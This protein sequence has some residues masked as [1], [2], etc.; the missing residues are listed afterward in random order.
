MKKEEIYFLRKIGISITDEKEVITTDSID[1]YPD[2][3]TFL[4]EM[5]RIASGED[6][7]KVYPTMKKSVYTSCMMHYTI[8]VFRK[9]LISYEIVNEVFQRAK[10]VL[11]SIGSK[12]IIALTLLYEG[13]YYLHPESYPVYEEA[14]YSKTIKCFTEIFGP[15]IKR[16]E[17][18]KDFSVTYGK[19][20]EAYMDLYHNFI[21]LE[22]NYER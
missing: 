2:I 9:G 5:N 15:I 22:K 19:E 13:P 6:W 16:V 14:G 8:E 20:Y 3:P 1:K 18:N 11:K 17:E 7:M 21:K 12:R 4:E 10:Y